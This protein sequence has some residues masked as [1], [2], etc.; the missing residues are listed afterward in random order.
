MGGSDDWRRAAAEAERRGQ[1]SE[2]ACCPQAPRRRP[3]AGG[4]SPPSQLGEIATVPGWRL[5]TVPAHAGSI[6]RSTSFEGYRVCSGPSGYVSTEWDRD[7]MRF[8]R[9]GNRWTTS[10]WRDTTITTVTPPPER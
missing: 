8:G 7:G 10:R 5:V 3:P 4:Y 1:R 6:T 9:D 2:A